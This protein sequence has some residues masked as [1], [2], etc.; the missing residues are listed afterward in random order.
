LSTKIFRPLNNKLGKLPEFESGVFGI[1]IS[2][3]SVRVFFAFY[4]PMS[5]SNL[6][7]TT[8]SSLMSKFQSCIRTSKRVLRHEPSIATFLFL[9]LAFLVR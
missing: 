1:P 6:S 7:K 8:T 9:E 3:G 4:L 5:L 2:S